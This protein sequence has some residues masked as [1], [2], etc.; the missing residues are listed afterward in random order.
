MIHNLLLDEV[1]ELVNSLQNNGFF[2]PLKVTLMMVCVLI[3]LFLL[4]SM[5]TTAKPHNR[6]TSVI[7]TNW[8]AN[9]H[10]SLFTLFIRLENRA[11][12][13]HEPKE[14]NNTLFSNVL[15]LATSIDLHDLRSFIG[16]E[17]PGF[18]TYERNIIIASESFQDEDL[19]AHESGPPL[20]DILE[21]RE[22]VPEEKE[23]VKELPQNDQK[24]VFLYSSHNRESFLP[25]LP[26]ETDPNRAYHKKIN[27]TKVSE[28]LARRLEERGI[29]TYVDKTDIMAILQEK[30]WKYGSS[31]RA[32]R[33]VVVAALKK[34]TDLQY[35]FDIHRDSLPYKKTTVYIDDVAYGAI[36]FVVG[37]EHKHYEK[38]LKLATQLHKR[39][40]EKYPGLSKGVV[41]KEG[42]NANG[43]Y[44]QDL[45]ENALLL[46]IG[47]YDNHLEEIY[48]S[49]DAFAEIF[50]DYY[51]SS[52]D[53]AK[54]P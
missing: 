54:K 1:E 15:Q 3:L 29:G 14:S 33:P 10:D 32:S 43:V 5:M 7:F 38:N 4:I 20:E 40:E 17:L 6:F 16:Q 45:S 35:L 48:R 19:F 2:H 44:N 47:G 52:R 31:Y 50:H 49:V 11:F 24:V 23:E 41:T 28:R 18:T 13:L 21:E 37:A 25:H 22:A 46:E 12:M 36:L 53:V 34:H 42:P 9:M 26:D 39:L 30:G 8:T 51:D 27:I